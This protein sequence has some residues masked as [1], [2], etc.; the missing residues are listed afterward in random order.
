[1]FE[2]LKRAKRI[3]DQYARRLN[4][5]YVKSRFV[6][7][8][9]RMLKARTKRPSPATR[10][11]GLFSRALLSF[12]QRILP[13]FFLSKAPVCRF[14]IPPWLWLWLST[15]LQSWPSPLNCLP[16]QY[17]TNGCPKQV[18]HCSFR[19]SFLRAIWLSAQ[20]KQKA[21]TLT[22]FIYPFTQTFVPAIGRYNGGL[23]GWK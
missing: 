20:F 19:H 9:I 10:A 15:F 6:L 23:R 21:N 1:M 5:L 11:K 17:H 13:K 16:A 8:Y 7:P 12:V 2:N 4:W 14:D 3:K 18:F 22:R